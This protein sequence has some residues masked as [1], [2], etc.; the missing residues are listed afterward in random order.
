MQFIKFNKARV[1]TGEE[2]L[3]IDFILLSIYK[4]I[5]VSWHMKKLRNHRYWVS[6]KFF[7][8]FFFF[9]L[10]YN[11]S[12]P[13]GSILYLPPIF[14]SL[15]VVNFSYRPP[16]PQSLNLAH[17]QSILVIFK[18]RFSENMWLNLSFYLY[19]GY[20]YNTQKFEC[21]T[22]ECYRSRGRRWKEASS[23]LWRS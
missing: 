12:D 15:L 9:T 8:F 13:R 5:R 3:K 19:F 20:V 10:F 22:A 23:S 7:F 17:L 21:D 4:I 6:F 14:V 2:G 1:P 11:D 16:V 18:W